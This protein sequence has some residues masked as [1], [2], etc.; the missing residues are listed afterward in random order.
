MTLDAEP[1]VLGGARD[2]NLLHPLEDRQQ[3][4]RQR[5]AIES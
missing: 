2:L 1:P 3:L 4:V 5:V